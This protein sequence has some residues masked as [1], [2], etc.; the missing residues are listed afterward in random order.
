M[1]KTPVFG[2]FLEGAKIDVFTRKTQNIRCQ[3]LHKNDVTSKKRIL[4]QPHSNH[5]KNNHAK[6]QNTS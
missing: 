1:Q 5:T 4:Y 6:Q 3:I 2:A